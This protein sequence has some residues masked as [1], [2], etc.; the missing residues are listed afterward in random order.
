MTRHGDDTGTSLQTGAAAPA[1]GSPVS[2]ADRL[3]MRLV[4]HAANRAPAQLAARLEEEWLADCSEQRGGF[5]RL[6]FALG[7]CQAT[8]AIAGEFALPASSVA[9]SDGSP[10]VAIAG[11]AGTPLLSPRMTVLLLIVAF[12]ALVVFALAS[13]LA[14]RAVEKVAPHLTVSFLQPPPRPVR[15][16]STVEPPVFRQHVLTIPEPRLVASDTSEMVADG[17]P[18]VP[19]GPALPPAT[20]SAGPAVRVAGGPGV[21]FPNTQDFY[22]A[23]SRR[24][25]ETGSA[26]VRVCV[27]KAGRLSDTPVVLTT[28]GSRRLDDGALQLA[29]AGSGHYR[30][31]T[32]DGRPV[33]SCYPFRIRFELRD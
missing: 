23:T 33:E 25:R 1:A 10:D 28:S 32:E 4:R 14:R 15:V 11:P 29:R 18:T 13:G 20:D 8:H 16:I 22:P 26:T 12:H 19:A 2:I 27:D 21:G 9:A 5:A 7:C 3:A 6:C 31:T 17:E 24:L 30:A